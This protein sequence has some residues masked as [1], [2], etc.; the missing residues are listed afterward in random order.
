MDIVERWRWTGYFAETL[1]TDG[2]VLVHEDQENH[3][4]ANYNIVDEILLDEVIKV[5]DRLNNVKAV[6]CDDI[7]EERLKSCASDLAAEYTWRLDVGYDT[8]YI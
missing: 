3:E 5:I 2:E 7:K 6:A 8:V 4:V 1:K